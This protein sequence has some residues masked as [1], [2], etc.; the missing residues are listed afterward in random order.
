MHLSI[1]DLAF[2]TADSTP[3]IALGLS[4]DESDIYSGG[5]KVF[6]Y[7]SHVGSELSLFDVLYM[8]YGYVD[9]DFAGVNGSTYGAGLSMKYKGIVGVR[10]D[11]ASYPVNNDLLSRWDRYGITFFVDPYRWAQGR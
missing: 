7:A 8:R 3:A 4:W 5:R 11:W 2:V 10:A 1:L 6:D 9:D